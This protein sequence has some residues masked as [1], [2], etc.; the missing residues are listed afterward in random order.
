MI[1]GICGEAGSGKDTVADFMVKNHGFVKISLADKIK[2]ICKDVFDFSDEQLWGASKHRNEP[3]TRYFRYNVESAHGNVPQYLSP[4]HALQQLGTEWGRACYK[5]IWVDHT[6]RVAKALLTADPKDGVFY[7]RKRG[8]GSFPGTTECDVAKGVV[9]SDVRFYN[10][11]LAI[12]NAGGRVIRLKRATSL[13]ESYQNHQSELEMK[14]LSDDIFHATINNQD[15]TLDQ[16]E[17]AVACTL[18][19]LIGQSR[20]TLKP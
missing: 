6:L 7:D 15:F 17:I 8:L 5:N 20:G 14:S 12:T 10:E 4:R 18:E 9:I 3:D 19:T 1:V 11:A 13:D 16:L 2:Q